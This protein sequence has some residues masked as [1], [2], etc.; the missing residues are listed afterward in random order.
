LQ[1]IS[2][3]R[4][5]AGVGSGWLEAEFAA[6]GEDFAGRGA[7]T[8]GRVDLIRAALAGERDDFAAATSPVPFL[9]AGNGPRILRRATLLDGWHPIA[10]QPEQIRAGVAALPPS[11]R[12]ALRTRLGLG[13]ERRERPLFG[14]HDEIAADLMAF[15]EAGV[16]DLVVDHTS[17]TLADIERD[18]R[19]LAKLNGAVGD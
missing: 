11:C 5:V 3:G 1:D 7:T 2:A 9:A 8:D 19:E 17:T 10:Q 16:T 4:V 12:V 6:L 14:T 15:A 13:K 18:V